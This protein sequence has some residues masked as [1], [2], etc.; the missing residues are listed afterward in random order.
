MFAVV[1]VATLPL[2]MASTILLEVQGN[3]GGFFTKICLVAAGVFFD[4]ASRAAMLATIAVAYRD[5]GLQPDQ[6]SRE[7]VAT[8][9]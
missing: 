4:F 3:L 5:W 6:A 7:R 9:A 2:M 1:S 8:I